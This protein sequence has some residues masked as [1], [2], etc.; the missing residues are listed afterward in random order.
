MA[1]C[2]T[3]WRSG[4][5]ERGTCELCAPADL[6]LLQQNHRSSFKNCFNRENCRVQAPPSKFILLSFL[7]ECSTNCISFKPFPKPSHPQTKLSFT[8]TELWE[9]PPGIIFH[10]LKWTEPGLSAKG[11]YKPGHGVKQTLCF[12]EESI[13]FYNPISKQNK[14]SWF[15]NPRQDIIS[16]FRFLDLAWPPTTPTKPWIN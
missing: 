5:A 14:P 13:M 16:F 10:F 12:G 15:H 9:L 7:L 4:G 1:G 2:V 11:F 3:A 8:G 6:A